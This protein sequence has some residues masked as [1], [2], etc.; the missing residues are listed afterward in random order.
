MFTWIVATVLALLPACC[1]WGS[2]P[3]A[4]GPEVRQFA[5]HRSEPNT[6]FAAT[7]RG[8]FKSTDGG[9]TWRDSSGGTL[10]RANVWSLVLSPS[11]PSELLA[12]G[13][14]DGVYRTRDAGQTWVRL[15][16][17]VALR[18]WSEE[19]SDHSSPTA[20]AMHPSK[21]STLLLGATTGVFRS[22]DGGESWTHVLGGKGSEVM[23]EG[24]SY[25]PGTPEHILVGMRG[26]MMISLDGGTT[27]KILESESL[28]PYTKRW[29]GNFTVRHRPTPAIYVNAAGRTLVSVDAGQS[30]REQLGACGRIAASD[31]GTLL[32]SCVIPLESSSGVRISIDGGRISKSNDE[33]RSWTPIM[34]GLPGSWF[35]P[36]VFVHPGNNSVYFAGWANGR[37]FRTINA[38]QDWQDVSTGL[39]WCDIALREPEVLSQHGI[40]CPSSRSDE[41]RTEALKPRSVPKLP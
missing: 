39:T 30:W 12:V 17:P 38:G 31:S 15:A 23:V 6:I 27:W 21:P 14:L 34:S 33:G 19:G 40:C 4:L 24:I 11:D 5:V 35:A 18:R 32:S 1:A 8:V 13:A 26:G 2:A 28:S 36:T 16:Q 22:L 3:P 37:V 20:L 9:A 29:F 10:R 7:A 41:K 25:D